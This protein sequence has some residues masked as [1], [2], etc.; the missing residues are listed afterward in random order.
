MLH[1]YSSSS[2]SESSSDE[3]RFDDEWMH[4]ALNIFFF[5]CLPTKRPKKLSSRAVLGIIETGK[6]EIACREADAFEVPEA[7]NAGKFLF[8]SRF[9]IMLQRERVRSKGSFGA[10]ALR[11]SSHL[12]SGVQRPLRICHWNSTLD[13]TLP[14]PHINGFVQ[15]LNIRL[16][17]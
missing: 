2:S 9:G 1:A 16:L 3:F 10:P 17:Q 5:P 11:G 7:K 13:S 6:G 12:C 14:C 8:R 4:M 15:Q